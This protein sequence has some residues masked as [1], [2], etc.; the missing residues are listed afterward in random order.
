[1]SGLHN[2]YPDHFYRRNNLF[3]TYLGGG[4]LPA[5]A[6]RTRTIP[7]QQRAKRSQSRLRLPN[8][9]R[10][11]LVFLLAELTPTERDR[12]ARLVSSARRLPRPPGG[13]ERDAL[14]NLLLRIGPDDCRRYL[15]ELRERQSCGAPL[16]RPEV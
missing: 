16:L 10:D 13:E 11:L 4:K 15:R 12:W 6:V 2:T 7:A 9:C 3:S 8:A 5:E 1:M 14:G